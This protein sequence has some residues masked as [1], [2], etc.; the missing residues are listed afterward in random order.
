VPLPISDVKTLPLMRLQQTNEF[1]DAINESLTSDESLTSE[2][3]NID[4]DV[5][6]NVDNIINASSTSEN[7]TFQ[8]TG[9]V[10]PSPTPL[11]R[12][13]HFKHILTRFEDFCI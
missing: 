12:S 11:V 8:I 10:L 1:D 7:A 4:H 6:Y 3:P 13:S 9:L 5:S 2:D